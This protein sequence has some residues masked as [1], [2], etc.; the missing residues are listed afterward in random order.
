MYDTQL[1]GERL[2]RP[3]VAPHPGGSN[4]TKIKSLSPFKNWLFLDGYLEKH[5]SESAKPL[6]RLERT[7]LR[8]KKPTQNSVLIIIC[9]WSAQQDLICH[10]ALKFPDARVLIVAQR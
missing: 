8:L 10:A 7:F 3:G 6:G 2:H 1:I 5:A 4:K 9:V